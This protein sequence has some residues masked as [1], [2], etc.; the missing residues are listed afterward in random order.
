MLAREKLRSRNSSSGTS[1]SRFTRDC[2]HTNA[3]NRI[4]PTMSNSGTEIGP[5]ICPQLYVSPSWMANT[6]QSRPVADSPTPTQSNAWE[7]VRS[8]GTSRHAST[9]PT[10]P[11]GMLM[12]KI[13]SH[14]KASIRTPPRIGPTSVAIPAVAPHSAIA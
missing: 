6:P 8:D 9:K 14:P 13:H 2:H 10:T 4:A 12:K 3:P 11:T 5:A 1:G 7:C